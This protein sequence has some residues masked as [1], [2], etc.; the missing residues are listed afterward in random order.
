MADCEWQRDTLNIDKHLSLLLKEDAELFDL[1]TTIR[2][3]LGLGANDLAWWQ[4]LV[5]AILVFI[6][7]LLM[8]RLGEKRFLGKNTAF[9]VILGIVFGSVM[10]R[11]ITG[12]SPFFPTLVAG[13][14]LILLH[15]L[16]AAVA[17][18]S[19]WFGDMVKGRSRILVKDGEIL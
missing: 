9:D 13:F 4:M 18:R 7:A 14:T 2:E 16:F 3:I 6:V 11:A 19:D 12:S 5:R 8:V 1:E 15:W 10:S 17:F